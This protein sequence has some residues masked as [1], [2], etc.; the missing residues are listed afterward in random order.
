MSISLTS[1]YYPA[2]PDGTNVYTEVKTFL[3]KKHSTINM[4]KS[5]ETF[6]NSTLSV[7]GNHLI[8]A[9]RKLTEHFIPM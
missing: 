6:G 2:L 4:Y 3:D 8:Y 1:I 5:I 9:R 7:S